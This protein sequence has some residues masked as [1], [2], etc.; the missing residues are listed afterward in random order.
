MAEEKRTIAYICPA[1][2]QS[3]ILERSIFQLAAAPNE[4]PCPCGK[5]ALRVE[6]MGDRIEMDVPCAFCGKDHHVT[7]QSNDFFHRRGLAFSCNRSGLDC[8]YVGEEDT[9]FAAVRRLEEAVDKV[10]RDAAERGTFLDEIVM[11]EVLSEIRDIARRGGVSCSCGSKKWK[12]EINYSSVDL[13]CAECGGDLRIPAATQS[14]I[15]DICCK[16]TLRIHGRKG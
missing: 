10:D 4:L 15:E 7:C 6:M 16:P 1:C 5:S 2:K 12:L 11:H 13:V 8:C 14:D 3:V 9:V